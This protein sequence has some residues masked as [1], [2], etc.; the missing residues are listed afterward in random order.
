MK[1]ICKIYDTVLLILRNDPQARNSDR[2][3]IVLVYS[4]LGV[5]TTRP[6]EDV[7]LDKKSPSVESIRRARQKAQQLFPELS[8][9]QDVSEARTKN[10]QNTKLWAVSGGANG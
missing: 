7:L 2:Y 6:F 1:R 8:A 3:L 4:A 5:D 9:S 10:A